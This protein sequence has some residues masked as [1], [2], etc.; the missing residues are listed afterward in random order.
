MLLKSARSD[1]SWADALR[2]DRPSTEAVSLA[3]DRDPPSRNERVGTEKAKALPA[4]GAKR[5]KQR[6]HTAAH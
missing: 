2:G 3:P 1:S 5:A 4:D 6:R